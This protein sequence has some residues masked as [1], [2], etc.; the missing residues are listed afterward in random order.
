MISFIT[1]E[2]CLETLAHANHLDSIVAALDVL[3][4]DLTRVEAGQVEELLAA[5]LRGK[6]SYDTSLGAVMAKA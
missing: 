3:E 6:A 1:Q 4:A 5:F 2:G